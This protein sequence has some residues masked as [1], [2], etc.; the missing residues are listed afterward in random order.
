MELYLIL[1]DFSVPQRASVG[2]RFFTSLGYASVPKKM[3][4]K[5]G[6]TA[7]YYLKLSGER[8]GKEEITALLY[9]D[10][11]YPHKYSL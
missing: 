2:E 10:L 3:K 7:D 5:L 8:S 1:I 6:E 9:T 11:S 4:K